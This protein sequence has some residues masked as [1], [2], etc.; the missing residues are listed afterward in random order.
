MIFLCYLY[1]LVFREISTP[2]LA[3]LTMV[4]YYSDMTRTNYCTVGAHFHLPTKKSICQNKAYLFEKDAILSGTKNKLSKSGDV[5]DT[6]CGVQ[7][8]D[9][10]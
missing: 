7:M 6:G 2:H 9:D 3:K 5:D 10:Y 1:K 8:T 4:R